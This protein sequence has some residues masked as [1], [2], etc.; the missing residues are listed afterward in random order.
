VVRL[1]SH[2]K[3]CRLDLKG[4]RLDLQECSQGCRVDLKGCKLDH[5]A[6]RLNP[7]FH[8]A[9]QVKCHL[10]AVSPRAALRKWAG[11]E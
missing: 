3:G 8:L 6:V 9:L 11:L 2:L 10:A 1:T 5:Q 4:C 7:A